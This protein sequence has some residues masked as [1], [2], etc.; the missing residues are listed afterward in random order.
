MKQ[1]KEAKSK[2]LMPT[3]I[4]LPDLIAS[5]SIMPNKVYQC[6]ICCMRRRKKPWTSHR[7][8]CPSK[9]RSMIVSTKPSI[10]AFS[11]E[12]HQLRT[13]ARPTSERKHKAIWA[14]ILYSF[15]KKKIRTYWIS[16]IRV[17]E[18]GSLPG[19]SIKSNWYTDKAIV[20]HMKTTFKIVL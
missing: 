15:T 17:A 4:R 1:D 19:L 18:A 16:C 20:H 8:H 9:S 3:M 11:I 10:T 6:K 14:T 7:P 5:N 2:A 12:N 13:P